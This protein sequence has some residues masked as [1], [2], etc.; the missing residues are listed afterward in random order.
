[1]NQDQIAAVKRTPLYSLHK[2][3][4]G[5][6]VS[7]AGYEMPVQYPTGIKTEHEHTRNKVSL[8]DISHMGQI[9]I[10]GNTVAENLEKLVPGDIQGLEVFHQRYSV[11]TNTS[12]GIIDDLMI[13]RLPDCFFLVVNAACKDDDFEYLKSTIG[14]E[15]EV[16]SLTNK[17]LLALQGPLAVSVLSDFDADISKLPFL[18]A[19]QFTLSGI[20]CLI[21]RCGYTGE[22]G[23]EISVESDEAENLARMLLNDNRVILA[24]LGARDTL[25]LEAGLCLYGQDLDTT[26]SPVEAGL[27]WVIAKKYRGEQSVNPEFPGAET[28]LRQISEGPLKIRRGFR[29]EGRVPVRAGTTILDREGKK[30]G[31]ISSGGYGQTIGGPIAMGYVNTSSMENDE[32]KVEIRNHTYTLTKTSLPFVSHRYYI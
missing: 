26:I 20:D 15:N 12:G 27:T 2:E 25:R 29:P 11:F 28:I 10:T 18:G 17:A 3:L 32:Y 9:K 13:T 21:H 22:D 14:I 16:I 24:G 30:V 23:F 4:Q 31:I 5:R 8:F 6:I 7:F 1:M 19:G